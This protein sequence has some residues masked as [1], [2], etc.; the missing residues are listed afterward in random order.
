MTEFEIFVKLDA[1]AGVEEEEDDDF[2]I[3][4]NNS[5]SSDGAA[6]GDSATTESYFSE[7]KVAKLFQ[8]SGPVYPGFRTISTI[9]AVIFF[10]VLVTAFT[11]VF[12]KL[13]HSYQAKK[14]G[15]YDIVFDQHDKAY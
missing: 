9:A 1:S 8:A 15:S 7:E 6:E 5:S 13:T 10:S 12:R 14:N 2:Y 4:S 3:P 11:D